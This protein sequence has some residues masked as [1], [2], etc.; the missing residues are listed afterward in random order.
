VD[1]PHSCARVHIP[2]PLVFSHYEA[3]PPTDF[4]AGL[5]ELKKYKE[6]TGDLFV[7][8]AHVVTLED[9]TTVKLGKWVQRQRQ[10][11]KNTCV[12]DL[13]EMLGVVLAV[14]A[15]IPQAFICSPR[16]PPSLLRDGVGSSRRRNARGSGR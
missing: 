12:L 15:A 8:Q 5:A 6:A 14:T 11:Y 9:G 16:V 1:E 4:G 13:K 10:L 2:P 3:P 7:P